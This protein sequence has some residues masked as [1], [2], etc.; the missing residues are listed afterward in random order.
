MPWNVSLYQKAVHIPKDMA[1][2][3]ILFVD[4]LVDYV[5]QSDH[6]RSRLMNDH[7]VYEKD[8]HTHI[9]VISE[10]SYD[11]RLTLERYFNG[12]YNPPNSYSGTEKQSI[13]KDDPWFVKTHAERRAL[14]QG[15]AF[16][17]FDIPAEIPPNGIILESGLAQ[18]Q[19]GNN[20]FDAPSIIAFG[21][22]DI[23]PLF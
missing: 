12:K 16:D 13:D 22:D 8:V 20:R 3:Y 2:I 10:P 1:G 19:R 9:A 5:G 11:T 18:T 17:E 14:W 23:T 7:H 15:P 4:Q 6:I 21:P